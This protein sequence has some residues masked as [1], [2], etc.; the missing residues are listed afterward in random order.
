MYSQHYALLKIW[1]PVQGVCS[2][3]FFSS[4]F[5]E[6]RVVEALPNFSEVSGQHVIAMKKYTLKVHGKTICPR[7]FA[8]L[9]NI[10][11]GILLNLAKTSSNPVLELEVKLRYYPITDLLRLLSIKPKK[12][13][14]SLV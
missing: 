9:H 3:P 2:F 6:Q 4:F 12:F 13:K 14:K 5:E 10:S 7:T 8:R 1:F 11:Y